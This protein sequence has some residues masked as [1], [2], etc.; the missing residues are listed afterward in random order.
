MSRPARAGFTLVELLVVIAIIAVLAAIL[1]P[2]MAQARA[3]A[4]SAQCISDLRQVALALRMYVDDNDGCTP[5]PRYPTVPY[6]AFYDADSGPTCMVWWDLVLPYT[7]ST[8]LFYCPLLR[9]STFGYFG[10]ALLTD[11]RSEVGSHVELCTHP[12]Q[13]IFCTEVADLVRLVSPIE[14]ECTC[15]VPE[16][17]RH[18]GRLNTA[19]VDGHVKS[20]DIYSLWAESP[21]WQPVK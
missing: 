7:R 8:D 5:P 3:K 11:G 14:S 20:L 2:V 4:R 18:H 13:T 19:F 15:E 10:N 6:S 12:S 9:R 21:L 17:F 16:S 1:F